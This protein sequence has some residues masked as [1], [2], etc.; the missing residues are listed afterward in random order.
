MEDLVSMVEDAHKFKTG[1]KVDTPAWKGMYFGY[2]FEG[3]G[4]LYKS[5]DDLKINKSKHNTFMRN[6]T[7]HEPE[8]FDLIIKNELDYV[9]MHA[10]IT[11]EQ[12][13]S[14]NDILNKQ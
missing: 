11:K 1:D 7:P 2:E 12:R 9:S 3:F 10:R 5:L 14:I 4:F 13:D 8:V 6:I